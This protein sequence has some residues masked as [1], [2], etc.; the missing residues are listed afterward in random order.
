[1]S[2]IPAQWMNACKGLTLF[3]R[4]WQFRHARRRGLR[5]KVL[6]DLEGAIELCSITEGSRRGLDGGVST[7]NYVKANL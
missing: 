1:M 7:H 6:D 3:F 5:N 4:S 2:L